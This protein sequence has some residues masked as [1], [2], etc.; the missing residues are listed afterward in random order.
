MT[1]YGN[2]T[3][4]L[5]EGW[6]ASITEADRTMR[7]ALAAIPVGRR[8]E[9][10][11]DMMTWARNVS[12]SLLA[13][14]VS[15]LSAEGLSQPEAAAAMRISLNRLRRVLRVTK[16]DLYGKDWSRWEMP[17]HYHDIRHLMA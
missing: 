17:E 12:D 14:A 15:T 8:A 13:A 6:A 10:A 2:A 4:E 9:Y 5:D 11:D 7:A 1:T 3:D 16:T